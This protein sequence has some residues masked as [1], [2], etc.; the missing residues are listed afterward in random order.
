[1]DFRYGRRDYQCDLI[2]DSDSLMLRCFIVWY[3]QERME[4]MLERM[5]S[6]GS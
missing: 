1:M 6:Q 2:A 4:R 3:E 5:I